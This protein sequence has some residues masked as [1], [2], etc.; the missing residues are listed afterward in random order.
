MIIGERYRLS[1]IFFEGATGTICGHT[2][3]GAPLIRL[4][5]ELSG[6]ARGHVVY[7]LSDHSQTLAERLED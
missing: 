7:A 6:T 5:K 3:A 1:S 4:D 2:P